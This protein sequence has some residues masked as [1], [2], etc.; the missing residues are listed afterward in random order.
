M[1]ISAEDYDNLFK[2]FNELQREKEE[3]TKEL[4]RMRDQRE[5]VAMKAG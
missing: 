5:S 3:L 4:A 2:K 1:K